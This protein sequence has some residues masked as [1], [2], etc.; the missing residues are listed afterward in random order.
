MEDARARAQVQRQ[1]GVELDDV[2]WNIA[3]VVANSSFFGAHLN[4][5]AEEAAACRAAVEQ[6][7]PSQG[8][9]GLTNA[10]RR[11]VAIAARAIRASRCVPPT[12]GGMTTT[13]H[14]A[15]SSARE[16]TLEP[17][18]HT[19]ANIE[20]PFTLA[21]VYN[22]LKGA[23]TAQYVLATAHYA[24]EML[25]LQHIE[26]V[27]AATLAADVKNN[28]SGAWSKIAEDMSARVERLCGKRPNVKRDLDQ[29]GLMRFRE[30]R[31]HAMM[32]ILSKEEIAALVVRS[33]GDL[34]AWADDEVVE[35]VDDFEKVA[36]QL[37][38]TRAGGS[39]IPRCGS[40]AWP[41]G[42]PVLSPPFPLYARKRLSSL[43]SPLP[44]SHTAHLAS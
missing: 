31:V 20:K 26:G 17:H 14:E 6:A 28:S 18:A 37:S 1:L 3:K 25:R 34:K 12:A 5:A 7:A 15:A 13:S 40:A 44:A 27:D 33:R 36:M 4:D 11:T 22:R 29:N 38:S 30:Q 24:F 2:V 16:E 23:V 35:V 43:G 32:E 10:R 21:V 39:D 42:T 8:L 41:R 19:V 9:R